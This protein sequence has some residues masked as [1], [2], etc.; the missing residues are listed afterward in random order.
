MGQLQ[1]EGHPEMMG[2]GIVGKEAPEGGLSGEY[3]LQTSG[4]SQASIG[5]LTDG[6]Q[7]WSY[8]DYGWQVAPFRGPV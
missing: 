1:S 6:V 7:W 4:S 2:P 8:G 5:T 3:S